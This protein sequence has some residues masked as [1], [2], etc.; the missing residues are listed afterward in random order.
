MHRI[1]DQSSFGTHLLMNECRTTS[2]VCP[3]FNKAFK[4]AQT[5][6][7]LRVA[8]RLKQSLQ[9]SD[10]FSSHRQASVAPKHNTQHVVLN[11]I[12]Q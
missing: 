10:G 1:Q 4:T 9:R 8:S 2:R 5:Q 12:I 7:L 6:S 3:S 11:I